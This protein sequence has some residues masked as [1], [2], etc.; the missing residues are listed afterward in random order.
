MLTGKNIHINA[1]FCHITYSSFFPYSGNSMEQFCFYFKVSDVPFYLSS[2][3]KVRCI[4]KINPLNCACQYSPRNERHVFG[5][6]DKIPARTTYFW[7][8]LH[9]VRINNM[10]SASPA[11]FI[12]GRETAAVC[13]R[14]LHG[15]YSNPPSAT[16]PKP[17]QYVAEYY[18]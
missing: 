5:T 3:L 15:L 4:I 9:V 13:C 12:H 14:L 1:Y 6:N 8:E 11:P 2:T 16:A 10:L 17:R 18:L 7:H